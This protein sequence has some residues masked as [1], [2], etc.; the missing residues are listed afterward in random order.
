MATN[1][2]IVEFKLIKSSRGGQKLIEGGFVFDKQR[3]CSDVTHWQCE[4]KGECKARL[5]TKGMIIVKRTNEHLHGPDMIAVSCLETKTGIKRKAQETQDTTHHIIGEHLMTVT[6][7]SATKLPKID[8]IKR[9]IRRQRQI[10]NNVHPQPTSLGDLVLPVEYQQ[11]T[12]GDQFLLYDSGQEQSQRFLSFGTIQNIEMLRNS[13]IWLA[14]GTL[15]SAPSLFVQVY[16]IHSLRDG[17]NPFEDGH[18]IPCLFILLPSKTEAIYSRMWE[19][20]QTLCPDAQPT[21][22]IIDFEKAAINSFQI[23]WY[24]TNVKGCFFHLTQNMWLK[25]QAEGLQS[26]YNNDESVIK[27]RLKIRHLPALAFVSP[28]DVRDYFE[29][30][31]EHLPNPGLQGLVLY[32]EQTYIG[33]TLAGG[34]H[35][36]PLFPI[37][38]WNQ[39][40]EVTQGIPRTT[41]AVE[42]WHRSFN[43]T[44]GCYHPNIWRFIDALKREQGL[45]EVKQVKF[46]AGDKPTKRRK[47]NANEEG[48]KNLIQ[49]LS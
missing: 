31:I 5:H 16:V 9:T 33:R 19:Q 48:L 26:D 22:L 44:V 17:P 30:A 12:K 6:Q 10:A 2:D 11:T 35:Q 39:H 20:V 21:H 40:H 14:D 27:I 47:D 42:A 18:L 23:I 28:F 4:K 3:I 13:Q 25:I 38:M 15:K 36:E 24:N 34:F 43:A 49:L 46:I 32:F 41:N 8:S 1:Q 7:G 29:T 37:Q 45:V